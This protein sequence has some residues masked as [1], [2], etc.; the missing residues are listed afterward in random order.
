MIPRYSDGWSSLTSQEQREVNKEVKRDVKSKIKVIQKTKRYTKEELA[1]SVWEGHPSESKLI[2]RKKIK[3]DILVRLEIGKDSENKAIYQDI[4]TITGKKITGKK[5]WDEWEERGQVNAVINTV[6]TLCVNKL[7]SYLT[8]TTT[9]F[10]DSSLGNVYRVKNSDY[11]KFLNQVLGNEIFYSADE[12][13]KINLEKELRKKFQAPS[14][15]PDSADSPSS[16]P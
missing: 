14:A 6:S 5:A 10:K 1:P 4:G 11:R 15:A 9:N 2:G 8:T 7:Y 13:K 3:G 12:L 16:L